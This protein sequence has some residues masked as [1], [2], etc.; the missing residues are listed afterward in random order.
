[1]IKF[2]GKLYCSL[3]TIVAVIAVCGTIITAGRVTI[4][5]L[6]EQVA[7]SQDIV[8][9][10][11]TTNEVHRTYLF[12]KVKENHKEFWRLARI[13]KCESNWD[14]MAYNPKSKDFGLFQ[15]N[16]STWDSIAQQ[17]GLENYK[18]Y[19][20]E[21]LDFG[22]WIYQHYGTKPWNWSKSCWSK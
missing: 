5:L 10:E 22:F 13:I 19:W 21:N 3:P 6:S 20:K 14:E 12:E 8:L 16:Q 15:I 18:D 4:K 9:R 1:M 2:L 17:L 7:A 11:L